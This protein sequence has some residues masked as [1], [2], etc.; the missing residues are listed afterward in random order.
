MPVALGDRGQASQQNHPV[1]AH[2]R[3]SHPLRC[4]QPLHQQ[5][6]HLLPHSSILWVTLPFLD[7]SL[8]L[9]GRIPTSCLSPALSVPVQLHNGHCSVL[10]AT[11]D[12][13]VWI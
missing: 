1:P 8:L 2:L 10:L 11:S 5:W 12:A 9:Q 13:V 4:A 3:L 7:L 6:P